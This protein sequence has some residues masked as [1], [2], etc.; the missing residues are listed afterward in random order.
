MYDS[1]EV[2][3][4]LTAT[5]RNDRE[6]N[7]INMYVKGEKL[8]NWL[9]TSKEGQAINEEIQYIYAKALDEFASCSPTDIESINAAK[10]DLTVAKKIFE[11]F[12]GVFQDAD[13]AERELTEE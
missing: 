12:N 9:I 7:L 6:R 5:A 11:I 10:L 1:T 13:N 2:Y 3:E 4:E 8:R